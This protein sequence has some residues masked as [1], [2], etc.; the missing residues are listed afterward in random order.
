MRKWLCADLHVHTCLSPCADLTI[1][2]RRAVACARRRHLDM[3]AV[4]DHNSAENVTAACAAGR[5]KGVAVLPG[6]E[7]TTR[8]EVHLLAIFD[9]PRQALELQ[10]AVYARLPVGENDEKLFGYQIIANENDEVEGYNPRLLI[11]ATSWPLADAVKKIHELGGLA[12]PA[13][14]DR[15]AFGIVG[16]LGFIPEHLD[17]DALEISPQTTLDQIRQSVAGTSRF[18]IYHA[19]DAHELKDI[20]R[21]R[22]W[23]LVSAPTVTELRRIFR[24]PTHAGLRSQ[25]CHG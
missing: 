3:I 21:A 1:S 4:C 11:S 20:G 12:I 25:K 6:M 24:S 5:E 19:S 18:A 9:Q 22:T 14:V 7:I 23:F 10:A 13:H 17:L 16:Q 15:P 2:P 8:E